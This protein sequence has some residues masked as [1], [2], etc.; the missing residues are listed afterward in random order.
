ML[1]DVSRAR[2]LHQ[3]QLLLLGN[4]DQLVELF[5]IKREWFLAEHMFASIQRAFGVEVV[6]CVRGT[7]INRINVLALHQPRPAISGKYEEL[8]GSAYTS[9]YV[10]TALHPSSP[11]FFGPQDD[12]SS[13]DADLSI[14]RNFSA[15]ETDREPIAVIL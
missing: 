2:S 9:S 6:K 12:G 10:P 7:D 11:P 8:T 13:A 15:V 4:G 5:H 1:T 3:E 14:A